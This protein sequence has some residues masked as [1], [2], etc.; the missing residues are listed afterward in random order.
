M[1]GQWLYRLINFQGIIVVVIRRRRRFIGPQVYCAVVHK[2]S[3]LALCAHIS[4]QQATPVEICVNILQ[5]SFDRT[6][7]I[8]GTQLKR[9][10]KKGK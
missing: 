3:Q 2:G 4:V 7:Q 8:E 5:N 10:G 1:T 6:F 9:F